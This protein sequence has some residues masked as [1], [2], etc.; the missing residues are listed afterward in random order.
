VRVLL[1]GPDFEENLSIRY[2]A[3]SLQA[4]RHEALLAVFNSADDVE[5]VAEQAGEAEIVGLSVCF[6]SRAQEFLAL[7]RRIKELYPEKLIV[8]GGHYASC[9]AQPLLEH[10][11][12]LDIIA[13]HESEQTLLEIVA[14]AAK[15]KEDLP[16]I[17][18]IAYREDGQVRFTEKRRTMDDLDTLPFPVR[19][20]R[21]HSIAGVP[22]SFL[23]GSRG[24]Y[25]NCAY[26]CITTLHNLAPGKKFRQR[27]V[28]LIADEMAELYRERGTRQFVF[29]D[30]NFLVPSVA[31]NQ[32]RIEG[33]DKAF[34]S[35]GME[36][37]ALL[38]KCRPADANLDVLSRL[39][40]M[41]LV[42]IFMGIESAT[43][44]GLLTL[45]RHQTVGQSIR[46]LDICGE[47]DV[48]AQ[49]TIMTF[50]PDANLN[51][52]RA[53]LAFMRR[54]AGNPLN[55]CRAE[56]YAGTPLEKR[57]IAL[58]RARGDYRAREYSM[59]DPVADLACTISL[60]LFYDRNWGDGSLMQKTI[61]LDHMIAVRKRFHGRDDLCERAH[62]WVRAVN[63]DTLSLLEEVIELSASGVG[64][65]DAGALRKVHELKERE[66]R[67]RNQFLLQ[68][69][70][71][72][73]ELDE[74]RLPGRT[75]S[76]GSAPRFR[77]GR[78]VAAAVLAIGVQATLSTGPGMAEQPPAPMQQ[79]GGAQEKCCT[80]GGT[81]T[82]ASGA[83]VVNVSI[84]IINLATK[85]AVILNTDK[86]GQFTAKDLESGKY[87]VT[88]VANGFKTTVVKGVEVNA[89]KAARLD[90]R[91]EIGDWG[92]CCEYAAAPM[93]TQDAPVLD[94]VLRI[95]PFT[96]SVGEAHDGGTLRGIAKLVYGDRKMW[97]QIYAAN[98][99]VLGD[100][101]ALQ[102][103]MSLTIPPSHQPSPK[104]ETKV[105]P[106]Y[107]PEA[108]SQHVHGEVAMDVTL[109]DD[110]TVQEVKIIEGNPLLN[111]A[112][113]DA[114]KQWKY[115]PLTVHGK[116]V[117]R[118][119]VVLTFEKNG[120]VR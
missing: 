48:S 102:N 89:G 74:Y 114:V 19:A 55:F 67:T 5:A 112:A 83:V 70:R 113:T 8:G 51:T 17:N 116:P 108:A 115:R 61:G 11:P 79:S 107:P 14:A 46:A 3:S 42:R 47:L 96:Y 41:G 25:E 16:K 94:Y 117:N 95:R 92:G 76:A 30:D 58:G 6:Q 33:F 71:I 66:V 38:I 119:V 54:F 53:D 93:R 57:M 50:N 103:G 73:T 31:H 109:N 43:E 111:S 35:R 65:M 39:K 118:I 81:V 24:C 27:S 77:L 9:A 78:Q 34:K 36:D 91:L 20:G 1:A 45:D 69:L 44:M 88:A 64:K 59:Y 84:T 85:R 7:A 97:I 10:H 26:C 86:T 90:I 110:G 68:G 4:K 21:I 40:E 105:L 22:T 101:N 100:F 56:I 80:L 23:M 82:D 120:K 37:I 29:H 13:I 18:G 87:D 12:E 32:T 62:A 104:L 60:D 75:V 98:R 15:L 2:L 99:D 52:L 63:L 106:S 72:K 28:E 49:F